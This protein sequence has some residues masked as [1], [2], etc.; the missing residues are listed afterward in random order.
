MIQTQAF[1]TKTILQPRQNPQAQ[2]YW[3]I[4]IDMG[5]SSV[6]V[7]A[8]NIIAS[9][10]S[11]ARQV[12]YGTADHP[13]GGLE[14]TSIAYRDEDGKE[15]FVGAV[16]QDT[17][18]AGDADNSTATMY[19]RNR[20]YSPEFKTITRVGLA[21]GM[22]KNQFG[23]PSGKILH[24]QTGLPP[25]YMETDKSDLQS[26]LEGKHTF[27]IKLGANDWINFSFELNRENIDVMPQ[28]MG[29]LASISTDRNGGPLPEA[30]KYMSSNLLVVDPGFGTL[31]TFCIESHYPSSAKTWNNLGMLR[32]MQEA[33]LIIKDKYNTVYTVPS[34]QKLLGDGYF[35]Q[36]IDVRK[37]KKID[38]DEFASIINEA[39]KKVCMEALKTIDGFYNYLQNQDYLVITGGTG[40]AWF[41]Y[42]K[43]YY[44]D[45]ETLTIID[46]ASNDNLP[47]I[48]SNV[49]GYYMQQLNNLKK[50]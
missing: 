19:V 50:K 18:V 5:Y 27:S 29:T 34:M 36:R 17:T 8:P 40:A 30:K 33:I 2:K 15:W 43:E 41:N 26:S 42:I 37:T 45:L 21:L 46:G 48:F 23:D 12:P 20:Y 35:K 16:A 31:D 39:N 13:I 47:S 7:F 10:P 11:Y 32:V 49:R 22:M 1:K 44:K 25:E 28:P 3:G 6:K 4:A 14:K 38:G 24:V 9:F